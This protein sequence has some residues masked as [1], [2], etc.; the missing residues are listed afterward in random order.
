VHRLSAGV[1]LLALVLVPSAAAAQSSA[2]RPPQDAHRLQWHPKWRRVGAPEYVAT[3]LLGSGIVALHWL[4][5]ARDDLW[6]GPILHD[7]WM[8]DQL[9]LESRN[10][11]SRASTWSDA[12]DYGALAHLFV[13]DNLLVTAILDGNRDVAWQMFVINL[14]SY[15]ASTFVNRVTK[16]V[17]R[18]ARPYVEPCREDPEAD[19]RCGESSAYHAFYSGHATS[20]ATTAGLICAHHTHLAL[21]GGGLPDVAT[22]VAAVGAT[23]ATGALRIA[24]DNHWA[25]DVLVGH[26]TG[27]LA[28]Y[29][30]PTLLYYREPRTAPID[31]TGSRVQFTGFVLPRGDGAEIGIGGIF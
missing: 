6:S 19:E 2:P 21:Y 15:A 4:G 10:G 12:L 27:Y 11:R 14:Q 29:L 16:R 20:T 18:R 24:S 26:V 28:G 7:E 9:R 13:V 31:E 1:L 3:A 23:T 25:T 30:L 17:T 5:T 22:C 8:R